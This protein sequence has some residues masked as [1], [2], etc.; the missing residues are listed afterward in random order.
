MS[1]AATSRAVDKLACVSRVMLD[2][3]VL[4]LR[5]ENE[6]LQAKVSHHEYGPKA[7]E[8]R[9][10]LVNQANLGA[11]CHCYGCYCS[12]RFEAEDGMDYFPKSYLIRNI[13]VNDDE[14]T[15]ACL[16]KKCLLLQA[17]KLG[18]EVADLTAKGIHLVCDGEDDHVV[19]LMVDLP[20]DPVPASC[21]LIVW[22][23]PYS[24]YWKVEYG[25][26][27]SL[28]DFHKNPMLENLKALFN[29]MMIEENGNAFF[30]EPDTGE[31]YNK[32]S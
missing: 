31:N 23:N 8:E 10:A 15:R 25:P 16:I 11:V 5:K 28:K 6:E 18:F 4:D 24:S 17:K 21:H 9:L 12:K 19:A 1:D 22:N 2:Q 30:E 27:L 26:K 20:A 7:L 32:L 3:R 14:R 29:K 13:Q